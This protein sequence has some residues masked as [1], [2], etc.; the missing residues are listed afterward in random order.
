M[1][2][3]KNGITLIVLIITIIVL[4]ILAGVTINM[5]LGE[6]GIINKSRTAVA[7]Y[8]NAT[9][10]ENSQISNIDNQMD[11]YLLGIMRNG[12]S[13]EEINELIERKITEKLN[14][15]IN[16]DM[17]FTFIT[18]DNYYAKKY[19]NGILEIYGTYQSTMSTAYAWGSGYYAPLV[20]IT[21]PI[22]F[23]GTATVVP[24]LARTGSVNVFS[25]SLENT[26][27]TNFSFYPFSLGGKVTNV[28]YRVNYT[29]IGRWKE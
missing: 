19:E 26:T 12:L 24:V 21:Y 13:E 18:G 14:E 27:N 8:E 16:N 9:K 5:V 10:D 4:L 25:L 29:A 7:K 11:K 15:S 3:N 23:I 1:F 2:K 20:T 6:N 22:Q 17:K 28:P